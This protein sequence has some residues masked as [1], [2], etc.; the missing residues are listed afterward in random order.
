LEKCGRD[1]GREMTRI[2]TLHNAIDIRRTVKEICGSWKRNFARVER[3]GK[4]G[5]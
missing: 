3:W 2:G 1:I 4:Y 5:S